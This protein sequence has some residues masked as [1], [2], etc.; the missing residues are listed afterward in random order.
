MENIWTIGFEEET[1]RGSDTIPLG[2]RHLKHRRI[3][4][5]GT[6]DDSSVNLLIAQL[7]YLADES[8]E[9]VNLYINSPG[10]SVN[11]GLL[12]YDVLQSISVPVN[13]YCTGMAA[14][15]AA[16]ILASGKKGHRFILPHSKTMIH[17]PLVTDGVSGS[18]TSI[19]NL[20]ESI[21][22]TREIT[23]AILAKHTGKTLEEINRATSYDHYMN[24]EE[25]VAF[26]LC[27]GIRE[28]IFQQESRPGLR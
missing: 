14:S 6:I 15:M 27:D 18:A 19:A 24:A 26:G 13:M 8:P 2:A 4:L 9:P 5:N 12:L 7:I 25:S 17:E 1:N 11:A 21:L 16:I 23:N 22:K 28:N 10:G 3:F 20:S